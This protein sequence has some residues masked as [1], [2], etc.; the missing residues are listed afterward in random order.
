MNE[1]VEIKVILK[2]P[3]EVEKKLKELARF[4][5]AKDQLD[6]YFTPKHEDFFS[7]N[8]PVEYLRVRH[9]DGKDE[10]NYNYLHLNEKGILMKTDEYEVG[11][12]DPKMMSV[13]LE[14]LDMIHKISVTKHRKT[15][16]LG[17]FEICID[18]IE[19]IGYFVEVEAKKIIKSIE[20]TRDRCYE[21]LEEIGADWEDI[22]LSLRG[23][24]IMVLAKKEGKL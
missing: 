19:E 1:E 7:L 14:K 8:P 20:K 18:F 15:Y 4:I 17:D 9:E 16:E 22:P 2:N 13:I 21:I 23:Y 5:K 12:T 24:P 11:V 3:G 6:E 10:L